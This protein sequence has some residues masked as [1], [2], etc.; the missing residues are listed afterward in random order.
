MITETVGMR[1]LL[2]LIVKFWDH[3]DNVEVRKKPLV[4]DWGLSKPHNQLG[5]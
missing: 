2:L 1:D 5:A 4:G 3:L